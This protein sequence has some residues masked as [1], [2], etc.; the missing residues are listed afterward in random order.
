MGHWKENLQKTIEFSVPHISAYALTVEPNTN[1]EVLIHK[2]KLAPVSEAETINQFKYIMSFL[3]D[4]GFIHYEISNFCLPGFES[5]H[6]SAYWDGTPY[7]GIGPSAHS[8]NKT[9]RQ[10]NCSLMEKYIGSIEQNLIPFESEVLSPDQRY[11]EY[12]MTSLRT[13]KG[14]NTDFIKNDFGEKYSVHLLQSLQKY[15]SNGW[16]EILNNNICLTDEGKLFSDL[17]SSELFV[18][19]EG[20]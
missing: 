19:E 18:N 17:I 13:H 2:R 16:I 7:L 9:S 11:N 20:N 6:N 8:F 1:L 4:R 15:D 3:K 14:I 10:W 12:I 5:K